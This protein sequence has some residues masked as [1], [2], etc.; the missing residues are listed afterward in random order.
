TKAGGEAAARAV[1]PD[2]VIIRPSIVFGAGDDF[3]NRFARMAQLSPALPLIGG[4]QT[5][6]QPV[7]VDDVAKA[8]AAAVT[9]PAC[10]GQ[11]YELAG[12]SAYSCRELLELTLAETHRRRILLPIPFPV[13]ALMGKGGE[14]AGFLIAP[15]ITEDQVAMLK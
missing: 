13:A 5:R 1:Y 8:V 10:A 11:T 4:G 14:L 12:P 9:D 2:A 7:Y 3:F 6:F 15:P